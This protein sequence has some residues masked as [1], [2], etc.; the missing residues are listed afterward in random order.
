MKYDYE[1][2]DN[3]L[4]HIEVYSARWERLYSDFSSLDTEEKQLLIMWLKAA[5]EVGLEFGFEAGKKQNS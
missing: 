5:Y 3:W 4:D 1:P 2:F